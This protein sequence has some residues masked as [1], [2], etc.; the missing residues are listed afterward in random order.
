[1]PLL[2]DEVRALRADVKAIRE[3]VAPVITDR[4]SIFRAS[5]V[6]H[7]DTLNQPFTYYETEDT[8]CVEGEEGRNDTVPIIVIIIVI[9]IVSVAVVQ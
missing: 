8:V 6:G 3:K 5:S 4:D 1:M 2:L 9:I 7:I